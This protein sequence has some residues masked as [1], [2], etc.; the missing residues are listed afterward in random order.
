M[1]RAVAGNADAKRT[2]TPTEAPRER[3]RESEALGKAAPSPLAP[4]ASP[5]HPSTLRLRTW[6]S[7]GPPPPRA[8][9]LASL[10]DRITAVTFSGMPAKKPCVAVGALVTLNMESNAESLHLA[11]IRTRR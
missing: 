3:E 10:G 6:G 7:A 2:L 11:L 9:A 4:S 5:N 1:G 8:R